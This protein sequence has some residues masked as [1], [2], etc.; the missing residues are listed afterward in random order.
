LQD[1]KDDEDNEY[2][3]NLEDDSESERKSSTISANDVTSEPYKTH[4]HLESVDAGKSVTLKCD[5]E[6]DDNSVIIWYNESMIIV[7]GK[8]VLHDR[9][10]LNKDGSIT[11]KNVDVYDDAVYRSRI[12]PQKERVETKIVLQVNGAPKSIVIGHNQKQQENVAGQTLTYH[13]NEKDLRFKCNVGKARPHAKIAW[14]HNGNVIQE[15][16]DHEIKII[17]SDILSI[18]ILHARH[19]GEYECEASNEYGTIKA[20]FKI[21]VQC[22][23]LD[24]LIKV[25]YI[26]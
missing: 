3:A 21:D 25:N 16:K 22:K 12:F 24:K 13:A 23:S 5:G 26:Y 14:N 15:S 11:I 9:V 1:S 10:T 7:Q 4:E 20:G 6:V 19:A 18:K 8:S 2:D 17:D